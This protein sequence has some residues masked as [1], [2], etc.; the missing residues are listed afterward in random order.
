MPSSGAIPFAASGGD[1]LPPARRPSS[2]SPLDG[3]VDGSPEPRFSE[4]DVLH[5]ARPSGTGLA[6][7]EHETPLTHYD[8]GEAF[9]A[10]YQPAPGAGTAH[11]GNLAGARTCGKKA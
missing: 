10:E 7:R 1:S 2:I 5:V 6:V 4:V 9:S 8:R 11:R 3:A